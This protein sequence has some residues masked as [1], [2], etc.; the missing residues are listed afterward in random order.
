MNV[1]PV[2]HIPRRALPWRTAELTECGKPLADFPP[3]RIT[4]V[5][6]V[7]KLVRE[8]GAQ[9]A[10]FG[11]CMTCCSVRDALAVRRTASRDEDTVQA[12]ARE[13]AA[14]QH[15]SPPVAWPGQ[16]V[17]GR[18][19]DVLAHSQETWA[20][21]QRLVGELEAIA[22]LIEAHREEFDGYLEGRAEVPSLSERRDRRRVA[23]RRR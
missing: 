12:L 20:R 2:A 19:A 6:D 16:R 11:V 18:V 10:S 1:G 8:I 13:C 21:K 23:G 15:A 14:V 17:E 9:R 4:T 7:Q 22:A 3:E 5:E